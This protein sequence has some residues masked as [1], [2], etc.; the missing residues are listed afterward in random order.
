MGCDLPEDPTVFTAPKPYRITDLKQC[1]LS[2]ELCFRTGIDEDGLSAGKFRLK[3]Y[4][5]A[6]RKDVPATLHLLDERMAILRDHDP[7]FY[8]NDLFPMSWHQSSGCQP[9]RRGSQNC[10]VRPG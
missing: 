5:V 2:A 4:L 6:G 9:S 10:N 1:P 8:G 3:L 7:C